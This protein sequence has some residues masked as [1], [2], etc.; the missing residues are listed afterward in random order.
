MKLQMKDARL[1]V[2]RGE[3][4]PDALKKPQDDV[5]APAPK[6]E[7]VIREV[8]VV[9]P[10]TIDTAPIARAMSQQ[11]QMMVNAMEMLK[12]EPGQPAPM[13]WNFRITERDARGNI[14]AFTAE[15]K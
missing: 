14:V 4:S 6:P 1:K 2:M 8:P 5:A 10:V 13:K 9:S 12:P 15:A 11:A 7:P 3:V